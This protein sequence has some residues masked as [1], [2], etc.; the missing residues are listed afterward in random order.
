M[1]P[2]LEEGDRLLVVR[3]RRLRP[4]DVVALLDPE[5]TGRM[6]VKR[7]LSVTAAGVEV[8]G[9]N[10]EASRDSRHF[11]PVPPGDIAGRALYRYFPAARAGSLRGP[12][13]GT[14]GH[15]GPAPGG[16]RRSART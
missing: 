14:L 5:L 12:A 13:G 16:H 9:D 7:V 15:D 6:L 1:T 11:G 4:G 8:G 2:V 3:A 10:L